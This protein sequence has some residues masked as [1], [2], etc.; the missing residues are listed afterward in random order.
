MRQFDPRLVLLLCAAS[1]VGCEASRSPAS[2]FGLRDEAAEPDDE[3]GALT[4]EGFARQ[5]RALNK[6][7]PG[8]ANGDIDYCGAAGELCLAGEGD[9]DRHADCAPGL[10]CSGNVGA[11]YGFSAGIDVC[12]VDANG[13]PGFCTIANPCGHGEG[14]CNADFQCQPGHTCVGNIGADFGFTPG[15]DVCIFTAVGGVDYCSTS[16]PC[17]VG[18]G[19]CDSDAECLPGLTCEGNV[20]ANYGFTPGIDVCEGT[21]A[22]A[23][24]DAGVAADAG[25]VADSGVGG[26]DAGVSAGDMYRMVTGE[27]AFRDKSPGSGALG[28]TTRRD[29]TATVTLPFPFEFFGTTHPAGTSLVVTSNG[30]VFFGSGAADGAN[31]A[32]PP[33]SGSTEVIAPFWDALMHGFDAY[34]TTGADEVLIYWYSASA[35]PSL[36][37]VTFQVRLVR[38]GNLIEFTYYNAAPSG[39][40]ATVGISDATGQHVHQLACSPNCNPVQGKV[41]TFYPSD[42]TLFGYDIRPEALTPALPSFIYAGE[43][44]APRTATF[45]NAGNLDAPGAIYRL[46]ASPFGGPFVMSGNTIT[47][48]LQA[49]GVAPIPVGGTVD[50]FDPSATISLPST[51]GQYAIA[52]ALDHAGDLDRGNDLL[53]LGTVEVRPL[54]GACSVSTT[55]LP[56]ATVGQMY[57]VQL[58][59]SGCPGPQWSAPTLPAGLSVDASGRLSGV[60]TAAGAASYDFTVSERGYSS[61]TFGL[62]LVVQ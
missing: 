6:G 54:I 23:G 26:V 24:V 20:G 48:E 61:D 18:E 28:F 4:D 38:Q 45:D 7:V 47:Y 19:D 57:D 59:A 16:A 44:L 55:S 25:E 37:S 29:V 46:L 51:P 12:E 14:D 15:I 42:E 11:S 43:V 33:T 2:Q 52:L 17:T 56:P 8:A 1:L 60:P 50:E 21:L 22:D 39:F 13:T 5:G 31:T 36:A 34:A 9:C 3:A 30:R 10:V 27:R 35:S 32:L 62:V 49:D 40:S 41:V 58:S 53:R